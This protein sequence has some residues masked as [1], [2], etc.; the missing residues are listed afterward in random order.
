MES[1]LAAVDQPAVPAGNNSSGHWTTSTFSPRVSISVHRRVK[2]PA[3]LA[4]GLPR[5]RGE[6]GDSGRVE[7]T[8]LGCYQVRVAG[9][10]DHAV[11]A[12]RNGESDK[13]TLCTNRLTDR[14]FS[15]VFS[16]VLDYY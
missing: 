13:D 14:C 11:Y 15:A 8:D 16:V 9:G 3:G 5:P 7:D 4:G 2:L 12:E 6:P 10:V 1:S